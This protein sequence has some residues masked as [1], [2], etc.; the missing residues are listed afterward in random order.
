[1]KDKKHK[2]KEEEKLIVNGIMDNDKIRWKKIACVCSQDERDVIHRY[3][4]SNCL[5]CTFQNSEN[6]IFG[7]EYLSD[8]GI[9]KGLNGK[10]FEVDQ[11]IYDKDNN[12]TAKTH[13][14]KVK[15]ITIV[16]SSKYDDIIAYTM[17]S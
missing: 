2:P 14:V 4:I 12:P 13:K 7:S 1:M 5:H 17:K 10:C 6:T 3:P 11:V 8:T 16:R 9:K 15:E